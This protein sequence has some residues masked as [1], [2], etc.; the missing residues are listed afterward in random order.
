MT[1]TMPLLEHR[2]NI[3]TMMI[4]LLTSELVKEIDLD[5]VMTTYRQLDRELSE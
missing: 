3:A 4:G 5:S 2:L 1:E